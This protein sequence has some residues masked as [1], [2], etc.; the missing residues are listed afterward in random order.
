VYQAL[1][2]FSGETRGLLCPVWTGGYLKWGGVAMDP[3]PEE[4]WEDL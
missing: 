2:D 4:G 1:C 3:Q